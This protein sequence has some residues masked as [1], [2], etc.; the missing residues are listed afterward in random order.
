MEMGNGKMPEKYYQ[1]RLKG[2]GEKW[3]RMKKDCQ[4]SGI[5]QEQR[6]GMNTAV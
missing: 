2:K 3:D 1:L 6:E 5:L 4:T